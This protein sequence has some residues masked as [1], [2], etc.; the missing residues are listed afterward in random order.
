MMSTCQ[1]AK[2]ITYMRM[3]SKKAYGNHNHPDEASMQ[4]IMIIL[5]LSYCVISCHR[6]TLEKEKQ[7]LV[8]TE[9]GCRSATAGDSHFSGDKSFYFPHKQHVSVVECNTCHHGTSGQP[10]FSQS[11]GHGLCLDCHRQKNK[12]PVKCAGCHKK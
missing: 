10:I 1:Q 12:G 3:Y 8:P 4:K 5:F 2:K 7:R 6:N 11:L 9:T